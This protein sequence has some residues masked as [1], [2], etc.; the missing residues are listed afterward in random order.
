MTGVEKVP[1]GALQRQPEPVDLG[2]QQV[3][4][5]VAVQIPG[6]VD[7]RY[8]GAFRCAVGRGHFR[9]NL[10]GATVRIERFNPPAA[11]HD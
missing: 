6:D 9:E 5:T 2:D 11:V 1:S 10:P 4:E 7:P 8:S 3:V